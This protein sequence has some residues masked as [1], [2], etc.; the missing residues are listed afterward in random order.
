MQRFV[1]CTVYCGSIMATNRIF[2]FTLQRDDKHCA[3]LPLQGETGLQ[4]R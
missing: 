1:C 4:R 2:M 3:P